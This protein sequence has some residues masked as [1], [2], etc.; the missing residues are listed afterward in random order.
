MKLGVVGLSPGNGHPYSWSAICNG[1]D[2]FEMEKTR[3]PKIANYLKQQSWPECILNSATVDWIWCPNS[4]DSK[5]ISVA[6][7]I[8]NIAHS[9]PELIEKCDGILLARDDIV[10]REPILLE[11]LKSG[12][13]VFIDK[14]LSHSRKESEYLLSLQSGNCQIFTTS[15]IRFSEEIYLTV[16][17]LKSL[18][19]VRNVSA[20]TP[21]KWEFYSPHIIDPVISFL[22]ISSTPKLVSKII[23][24]GRVYLSLS[25]NSIG[26]E[27]I[28]DVNWLGSIEITYIGEYLSIT[29]I[30]T[31]SFSCF[32]NSISE[33]VKQWEANVISIPRVQTIISSDIFSMGVNND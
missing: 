27:L 28:S 23:T 6:S 10:L 22:N 11:I 18:G 3:F 15:S 8:L 9:L 7:K 5:S 4:E 1:Y 13:P 24:P 26:V 32:K 17:E 12:K 20:I 16:N 19:E 21:N 30:F 25:Y 33:A 31:D 14:P 2:H 29:K